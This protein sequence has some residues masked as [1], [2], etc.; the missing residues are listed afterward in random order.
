MLDNKFDLTG[1][2]YINKPKRNKTSSEHNDKFTTRVSSGYGTDK[3]Q[4]DKNNIDKNNQYAFNNNSY[5]ENNK[6]FID[7]ISDTQYEKAF[8]HMNL[9]TTHNNSVNEYKPDSSQ[10]DK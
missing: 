10:K 9:H 8:S 1:S 6:T 5:N 2:T 7:D 3:S 4:V